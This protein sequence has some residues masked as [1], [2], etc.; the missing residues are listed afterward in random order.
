MKI[1]SSNISMESEHLY[2]EASSAKQITI[3]TRAQEAVGKIEA[4]AEKHS[5]SMIAGI[6]EFTEVE[7]KNA[8]EQRK[9]ASQEGL[10]R[11]LE[12]MKENQ[13][14]PCFELNDEADLQI[15]LLRKLL[16]ALNGKGRLDPLEMAEMRRGEALDLRSSNIKKAEAAFSAHSFNGFSLSISVSGKAGGNTGKNT[17]NVA[18]APQIGTSA[19][20]TTWQKITATSGYHYESELTTFASK[21][22]AITDD[23]RKIEFGVEFSM[24]RSFSTQFESIT[25]ENIIVTDPLIINIDSK[26]AGLSDVKFK[27]DL[28]NDGKQDEISFAGEGSGF[29]ALDKDENGKIDNGSELFGTTSGDGFA[30]LA[31]YDED[32]NSWIDEN[33]SVYSKLK[34]WTKDIDGNDRLLNLKEANVG[35]IYLGSASTEFSIKDDT[36]ALKGTVRK[37]GIYLKETGEVGTIQ[38][39]DLVM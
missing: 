36:N 16:A 39:V 5:G 15:K 13:T 31:K 23:G 37:T 34:V 2:G 26:Y 3:T 38:H 17:A 33:D 19:T 25:S 32:G 11:M 30:D 21:G 20:G 22:L 7:E 27:F 8:E 10:R 29:L 9:Q 24:G 18:T 28:D 1:N 6:L 12:Q 35:A 14:Q 4:Y